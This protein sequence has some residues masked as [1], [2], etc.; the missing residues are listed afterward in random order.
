VADAAVPSPDPTRREV[1]VRAALNAGNVV[2]LDRGRARRRLRLVSIAAAALVA[3]S[4]AGL[5]IRAR[6]DDTSSTASRA[7]SPP[8]AAS[9]AATPQN[10]AAGSVESQ[11]FATEGALGSFSNRADLVT[12]VKNAVNA[13]LTAGAAA[14]TAAAPNGATTGTVPVCRSTAPAGATQTVLS[15]LAVLAGEAVQIDVYGLPDGSHRLVVTDRL[16]C[17]EVFSQTL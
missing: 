5:L 14:D 6:N 4:V 12:A 13:P 15:S 17:T 1:A 16:S 9:A 2:V 11:P 7:A 3:I 10:R 8:P